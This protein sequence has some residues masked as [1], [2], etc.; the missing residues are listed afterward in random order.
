MDTV[1]AVLRDRYGLHPRAAM[2]IQQAAA[3]FTARIMLQGVHGHAP[4]DARSVISLVSSG[5]RLGDAV[6]ITGEGDD[7]TEAVE[8]LRQL[9]EAGVCHP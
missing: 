4:A 9:L 5:I 1:D 6:R 7:A 2:R 3:R 8:V